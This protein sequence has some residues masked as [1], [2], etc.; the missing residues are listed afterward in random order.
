M[1]TLVCTCSAASFNTTTLLY[2][3]MVFS[4]NRT[5]FFMYDSIDVM[6][7]FSFFDKSVHLGMPCHGPSRRVA[8]AR[9]GFVCVSDLPLAV[10]CLFCK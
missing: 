10:I 1:T 4:G 6:L 8:V 9:G 3:I 2:P 7:E 5:P